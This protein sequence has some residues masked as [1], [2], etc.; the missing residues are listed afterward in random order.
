[1]RARILPAGRSVCQRRSPFRQTRR[2]GAAGNRRRRVSGLGGSGSGR[3]EWVVDVRRAGGVGSA[4]VTAQA[5]TIASCSKQPAPG[6]GWRRMGLWTIRASIPW[7]STMTLRLA[8]L[9]VVFCVALLGVQCSTPTDSRGERF[10]IPKLEPGTTYM[11]PVDEPVEQPSITP[12]QYHL[13]RPEAVGGVKVE[14]RDSIYCWYVYIDDESVAGND[15]SA[16]A[17]VDRCAVWIDHICKDMSNLGIELRL[18]S[19]SRAYEGGSIYSISWIETFRGLDIP[20]F[21][22]V[23]TVFK[24][25]KMAIDGRLASVVAAGE[26]RP[27]VPIDDAMKSLLDPKWQGGFVVNHL[28]S[29]NLREVIRVRLLTDD[30]FED[31]ERLGRSGVLRP[32]W[33]PGSGL[34]RQILGLD[35]WS[36]EKFF[37]LSAL[38][39]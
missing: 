3:G 11:F 17:A 27:V 10:Q 28:G 29:K 19:I 12:C 37:D 39:H 8:H 23:V 4:A 18:H 38:G 35:A 26:A 22:V 6:R 36:G 13:V 31:A 7:K 25:G 1:M 21:R 14:N 30:Y 32:F 2:D 34:S 33:V 9:L 16:A 20:Q 5:V 24:S 15:L